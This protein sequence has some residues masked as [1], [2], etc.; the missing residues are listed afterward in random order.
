MNDF[1][2]D[3]IRDVFS[4]IALS[5]KWLKAEELALQL[6]YSPSDVRSAISTLFKGGYISRSGERGSWVYQMNRS[7]DQKQIEEIASA[8]LTKEDFLEMS[9]IPESERQYFK[10]QRKIE[11]EILK[12]VI[13]RAK[14][15]HDVYLENLEKLAEASKGAYE[16]YLS[17]THLKKDKKL[18]S[19]KNLA[20]K[21]E[22]AFWNYVKKLPNTVNQDEPQI[23]ND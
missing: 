14:E 11:S 8:S 10:Y 13:D 23:N 9:P 16:K 17:K 3:I 12:E 7:L 6:S 20:Q 1:S 19:L 21:C 15:N 22:E 5:S 2:L 4:Q 18:A